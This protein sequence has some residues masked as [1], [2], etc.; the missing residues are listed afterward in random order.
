MYLPVG[1]LI[2]YLERNLIAPDCLDDD[3]MVFD[4]PDSSSFHIFFQ[5]ETKKVTTQPY[6]FEWR[7]RLP[8]SS[9]W[10]AIQKNYRAEDQPE[11]GYMPYLGDKNLDN[12]VS[13]YFT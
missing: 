8:I 12:A 10:T 2:F 1:A 11:L 9:T 13:K 5:G 3:E 7:E 6:V 4:V